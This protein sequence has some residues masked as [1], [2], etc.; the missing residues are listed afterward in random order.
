MPNP[1]TQRIDLERGRRESTR[2]NPLFSFPLS[3]FHSPFHLSLLGPLL[4]GRRSAQAHPPAPPLPSAVVLCSRVPRRD[5]APAAHLLRN[6]AAPEEGRVKSHNLPSSLFR[7]IDSLTP[8]PLLC[9]I[10]SLRPLFLS[11]SSS[12]SSGPDCYR[13][14]ELLSR[15]WTHYVPGAP[16]RSW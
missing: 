2:G 10:L 4:A 6:L 1:L 14:S 9:S 5:H 7:I 15:R 13:L 11:S 12:P 8:P 3:F 16:V